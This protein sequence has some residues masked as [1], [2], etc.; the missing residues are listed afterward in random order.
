MEIIITESQLS[1][2]LEQSNVYTDKEAYDNALEIYNEVWDAYKDSIEYFN[3]LK[4]K[5][6]NCCTEKPE[7]PLNVSMIKLLSDKMNKLNSYGLVLDKKYEIEWCGNDESEF[8]P[9]FAF[10]PNKP[11][12]N[13]NN[14][15]AR[16]LGQIFK[17]PTIL[18]PIYKTPEPVVNYRELK[19]ETSFA[20][21]IKSGTPIVQVGTYYMTYPEFEVYK[22]SKP[23]TKFNKQ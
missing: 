18:K 6:V 9:N 2:L 8:T 21:H 10:L 7:K 5:K 17:K 13:G 23:N 4:S 3:F 12:Y 15:S 16:L 22:K 14:C 19:S 11:E 20:P 1:L